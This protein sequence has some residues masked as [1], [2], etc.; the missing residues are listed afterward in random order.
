MPT[1][2]EPNAVEW[3]I[4]SGDFEPG[5]FEE[6]SRVAHDGLARLAQQTRAEAIDASLSLTEAAAQ[7]G[8][9]P[10]ELDLRRLY[11]FT[12]PSGATRVPVWVFDNAGNLLRGI[13][14]IAAAAGDMDYPSVLKF[15][16]SSQPDLR[17]MT[18]VEWLTSPSPDVT[19]VTELFDAYR[20]R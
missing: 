16:T 8:V 20:M 5:E 6:L 4:A 13:P 11:L 9:T 1:D 15:M 10:D 12:T 7:L 3:L 18:P 14:E 2:P 19:A 17:G